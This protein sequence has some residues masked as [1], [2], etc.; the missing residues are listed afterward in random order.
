VVLLA[1]ALV[2]AACGG[3]GKKSTSGKFSATIQTTAGNKRRELTE[4]ILQQQLRAAGF[5]LKI[6]NVKSDD[7][8]G[9]ILPKG[10]YQVSLYSGSTTSLFPYTCNIFCSKNIPTAPKFTGNNWQR[11]NIPAVDPLLER[12]ETS[13]DPAVGMQSNKQADPILAGANV[14]L[15]LDPLPNILLWSKAIT[16]P[17]QDNP[18][19]GPF[20]NMEQWTLN[21]A[22]GG[23]ATFSAEEEPACT[24][25]LGSCSGSLWGEYIANITTVPHPYTVV[26]SGSSW[27]YKPTS[28]IQGEATLVTAPK[29]V[30]TY[31]I[32]PQAKWSDGQ[33]ITSHDFKYV[34]DQIVHGTDIYD[35]TG[36]ANIESVDDSNPA[37]AVVTFSKPYADWKSLFGPSYGLLPAHLLEGKDRNKETANGYTWS[38]GPWKIDSWEKGAQMTL[39]PNTNYWGPKPKLAK[40]VFKFITDSSAEFQAFKSGQVQLMYPQPQPDAIDQIKAGIPGTNAVYTAD[41]GN[42]EALWFNN[43]VAPFNDARVRQAFGYA[44]D[45]AALVD[46]L[47]G[48]LGVKTPMNTINPPILKD[49]AEPNAWANYTL[50][51]NK[52]NQLMTAAGWKKG[53]DGIWAKG[54]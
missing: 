35:T 50:D 22:S 15:P 17:V 39:V 36:Y 37:Q 29:Q 53:S 32:N 34:W 41:T 3:G 48:P 24:D 8:F 13:L 2:A 40:V 4:Q 9:D 45:R 52:V 47:F 27:V 54:G 26:K 51:L 11:V 1:L 5:D 30:V 12:L 28:L 42:L 23:T 33:P 49:Y 16:G 31:R 10:D 25:W 38:G 18:I 44:I 20:W 7:L 19:Q 21:N 43:G 14:A 6:Q 46:R